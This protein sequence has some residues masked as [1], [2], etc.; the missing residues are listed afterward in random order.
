MIWFFV[1]SMSEFEWG[2]FLNNLKTNNNSPIK[3]HR[4]VEI[5]CIV[6]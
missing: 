5:L 2:K 3:I 4:N 1:I 6:S